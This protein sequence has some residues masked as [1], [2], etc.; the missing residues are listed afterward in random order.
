MTYLKNNNSLKA[1]KQL[2]KHKETCV[3][4]WAATYLLEIDTNLAADTLEEMKAMGIAHIPMDAKYTLMEWR[5]ADFEL[6]F[7]D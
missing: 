6:H 3:L 1:L 7:K 4:L 2:L 5:S